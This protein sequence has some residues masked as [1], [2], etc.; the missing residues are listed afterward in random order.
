M[1]KLEPYG[2]PKHNSATGRDWEI[3]GSG[4]IVGDCGIAKTS[5]WRPTGTRIFQKG[6][7]AGID[8]VIKNVDEAGAEFKRRAFAQLNSLSDGDVRKVADG[9]L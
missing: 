4:D 5:A 2:P 7:D 3:D 8:G 6:I 1:L 9:I